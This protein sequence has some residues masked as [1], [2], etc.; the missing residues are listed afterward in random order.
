M[1]AIFNII[2]K[3]EERNIRLKNDYCVEP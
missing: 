1:L 2:A 3:I